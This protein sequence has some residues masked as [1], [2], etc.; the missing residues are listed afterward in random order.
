MMI[1]LAAFVAIVAAVARYT[2]VHNEHCMV[3]ASRYTVCL[4][5]TP[6]IASITRSRSLATHILNKVYM[7]RNIYVFSYY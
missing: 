5:A 6:H 4:Q 3:N 2:H 7:T 1:P